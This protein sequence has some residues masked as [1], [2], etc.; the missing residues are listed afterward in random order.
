MAVEARWRAR[1]SRAAA[2]QPPQPPPQE[3]D[4]PRL[5]LASRLL[6]WFGAGRKKP[7]ATPAATPGAVQQQQPPP[8]PA[9]TG[10][11]EDDGPIPDRDLLF[12]EYVRIKT[13]SKFGLGQAASALMV[14]R[15][16]PSP[17]LSHQRT[18]SDHTGL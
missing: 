10:T 1:P 7:E 16:K 3:E 18:A 8:V 12:E 9:T 5:G 6:G 17:V 2:A 15:T 11:A 4:A 14:R 13:D